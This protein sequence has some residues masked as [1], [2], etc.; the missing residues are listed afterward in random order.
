MPDK[1]SRT[2]VEVVDVVQE[3][4]VL[5]VMEKPCKWSMIHQGTETGILTE[6]SLQGGRNGEWRCRVGNGR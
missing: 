2:N 4:D 5:L 6:A 3:G 1:I